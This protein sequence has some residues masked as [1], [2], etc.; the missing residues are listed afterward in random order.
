MRWQTI[1]VHWTIRLPAIV[2]EEEVE[3]EEEERKIIGNAYRLLGRWCE[4]MWVPFNWSRERDRGRVRRA[5][6]DTL[7]AGPCI[8]DGAYEARDIRSDAAARDWRDWRSSVSNSVK[9]IRNSIEF[10]VMGI[11][12]VGKLPGLEFTKLLGNAEFK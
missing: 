8:A 2:E 1:N 3:E 11:Q 9:I 10:Y 7:C 4:W 12:W 5:L 6:D